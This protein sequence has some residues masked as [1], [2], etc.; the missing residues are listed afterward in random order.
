MNILN[1]IFNQDNMLFSNLVDISNHGCQCSGFSASGRSC[2]QN[3]SSFL[4]TKL[5]K[6]R[7]KFQILHLRNSRSNG[8]KC[9]TEISLFPVNI[10][11]ITTNFQK[12][13]GNVNFTFFF[14]KLH[15]FFI[16]K[17]I[18]QTFGIFCCQTVISYL[19]QLPMNP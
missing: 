13:I 8:T 18:C 17:L 14:K 5:L 1:R 16:E 10:H 9:N 4:L 3:Q 12:G 2:Y 6:Y 7:R 11:P 15:F 19:F